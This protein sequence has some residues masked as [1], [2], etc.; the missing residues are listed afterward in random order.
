MQRARI[1]ILAVA[2]LLAAAGWFLLR[3]P[4]SS[5][6]ATDTTAARAGVATPPA[7]A[8]RAESGPTAAASAGSR[9]AGAAPTAERSTLADALNSPATDVNADLRLVA[10]ILGTFRT[11][12]RS[13]GN[14]TGSNAEITAALTGSNPLKL[15]LIP[16][17]HA[18][19]SREGELCDRW[20]TPFFFHAESSARMEIR[21]AGPDRKLWTDDDI[22]FAP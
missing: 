6:R 2:L 11:N 14:P 16:A 3:P 18:A 12:L 7:T 13:L 1:A 8:S 20:G 15:A 9:D 22:T 17:D 21:S 10:D 5:E 4:G 19:I